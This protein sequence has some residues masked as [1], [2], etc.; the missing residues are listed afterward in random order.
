MELSSD[1]M[2]K[3]Q[4]FLKSCI[5][6]EVLQQKPIFDSY[7]NFCDTVGQNAM[8]YRDFEFWY[9]RFYHGDLDF[10][11]DRSADPE[12]KTLVDMPVVLMNKI[13]RYLDPVD[14]TLLRSMNHAIKTVAD[15]FPP[16]FE[17]IEVAVSETNMT[18]SLNDKLFSCFKEGSGCTLLKPN[19]SK[20]EESEESYIK[21][22]L[23]YWIP[24]LK[25]PNME[26]NHFSLEVF[27]RTP[28]LNDLLSVPLNAKSV[29]ICSANTISVL[30]ILSAMTP[31]Y[32]ESI[33]LDGLCS[34]ELEDYR[35]VWEDI[36]LP[37]F[38]DYSL[39]FET[40]QFK[41]AQHVD[42]MMM[43]FNVADLAHFSHLKS[44]KFRLRSENIIE[45]VPRMRDIISTFEH[46]ESCE[47]EYVGFSGEVPIV[48]FA[49]ALGGEIQTDR[50]AQGE[51]RT[52]THLYHIPEFYECLEINLKD[53]G[54]FR[55]R[56]DIIKI[57]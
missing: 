49:M 29:S 47:L 38:S 41:Q 43:K 23:E 57:R 54:D 9:H 51:H 22:S 10:D 26:V 40:D 15:S 37:Y 18:W 44:F 30:Q 36:M 14:R 32:L 16:V 35:V 50:L 28:N 6:Y 33:C 53:I 13:V 46:F 2:K 25:I 3:N 20:S 19:S 48:A 45:D 56:I 21:K 8:E 42:F 39:I 17:K 52:I 5:F 31:G 12:P 4:H 27:D 11:Y 34:E 7:R 24:V 55:C 1:F